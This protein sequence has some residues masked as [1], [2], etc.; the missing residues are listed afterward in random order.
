MVYGNGITLKLKSPHY[1]ITKLLAR[2]KAD[3]FAKITKRDVPEEYY[4]F[5]DYIRGY[6]G[7]S[8]LDEQARLTVMRD[9]FNNQ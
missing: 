8:G 3:K 7:F 2:V 5:I 6:N 9:Y 1:L 4:G